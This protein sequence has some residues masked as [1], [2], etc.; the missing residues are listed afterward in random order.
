MGTK[1]ETLRLLVDNRAGVLDRIVGHIRREGWNIKSLN[2]MP[3]DEPKISTMKI[4]VE[5]RHTKLAQVADR[6]AELDCVQRVEIGSGTHRIV[7]ERRRAV[8][9]MDA[10]PKEEVPPT[11]VPAKA[12]GAKRILTINPGSTSTKMAVYEEEKLLVADVVR[13]D[14]AQLDGCGESVLSQGDLR[15][16]AVLDMLSQYGVEPSSLDAVAGRCGLVRPIESGTY[17]INDALLADLRSAAASMHASALGGVMAHDI[18]V[19]LGIPAYVV[20]PIV[21]DEM[22][23]NA[24]LTGMP[25]IERRSVFHALNQKAIARRCAADLGKSYESCRFVVAHM[26]GG[27]T[28]GAHHFGRVVDVNDALAGEGPFT[29]ER[30]GSIPALPLIQMC[31][32]G[33]YTQDELSALVTRGGGLQGYLGVNDVR[34]VERMIRDG[35]EFAA[36]VMDSMAYQISKEIGAMMA[37]LEGR[38]DAIVLT[39]G[40][41]NARRLTGAI[42]QR[43]DAMAPVHVYPGEDEM[44]ALMGGV[45]R[46]LRGEELPAEYL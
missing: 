29:P 13:H 20:D 6:M 22:D 15:K 38:A 18:A 5:G 21:V 32:S 3:G 28:V 23:P 35:D 39:G 43:V 11:A 37:V 4:Q 45:L 12:P 16:Q 2:V 44:L 9:A 17:P 25:G 46:V 8:S 36:L 26:G 1:T 7:R 41:A 24:K 30:T 40:M 42:R 10:A 19:E 27:V 31:F 33:E 14:R 34:I